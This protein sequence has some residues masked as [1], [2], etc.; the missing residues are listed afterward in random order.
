LRASIDEGR[1]NGPRIFAAGP[2]VTAPDGHPAG[3]LLVGNKAAIAAGTRQVTTP[4][5][6]RAVVRELAGGGVDVIKTGFDSAGRRGTP[7]RLPTLNAETLTSIVAEAHSLGLPVTTHWGNVE[8][9]PSIIAA[10]PAQIEHAGYA[11]IPNDL[12]SQIAAAG[13]VVD[14]TLVV[15]SSVATPEEFASGSLGNCRR[16]HAAGVIITAGTDAPLGK[17]RFGESLQRELEL[18]VEAGLSPMEAIQAATSRPASLLK[19]GNEIGTVQAGKRADLIAVAGDPLQ[20]ISNIRN[21]RI[22]IR[23]GKVLDSDR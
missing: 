15:L 13:I 8:E 21:I 7:H 3:T 4:E 18:L 16:L 12:I 2:L 22:V 10:R 11:P 17:L 19:R 5:E 9:L 1:R 20:A 14:P 6:G 23:D